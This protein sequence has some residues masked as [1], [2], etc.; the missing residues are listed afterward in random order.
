MLKRVN[1]VTVPVKDQARALDF[2]TKKVGLKVFTDQTM[3]DMRW[4]ELQVAGAETKLVLYLDPQ[5]VPGPTPAVA[6]I[7]DHVQATYEELSARGV[8]FVQPPKKEHWGEHAI[9]R[10]S[11]GNTILFAK[12]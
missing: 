1:F 2:Y 7:A 10:D 8:E 9:F 11:E 5:H 4:I 6:F 12:G 3:G